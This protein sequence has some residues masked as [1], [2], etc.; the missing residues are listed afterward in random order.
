LRYLKRLENGS[1]ARR[2]EA[3]KKA[4]AAGRYESAKKAASRHMATRTTAL[5]KAIARKSAATSRDL[6]YPWMRGEN[7]PMRRLSPKAE[8]ARSASHSESMEKYWRDPDWVRAHLEK[9]GRP[10]NRFEQ[11]VA[12]F[13]QQ[14]DLPFKFVGDWSFWLRTKTGKNKNP[15]FIHI[16]RGVRLALLAHGRYWHSPEKVRQE[17]MDYASC[18]WATLVVWDDQPLDQAVARKIARFAGLA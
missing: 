2:L 13:L 10:P 17:R 6:G 18:G 1:E 14:F 9:S 4:H 7:N 5:R 11:K 3:V 16:K 8:A 12:R 15:D